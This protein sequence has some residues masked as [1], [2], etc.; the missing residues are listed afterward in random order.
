M[1]DNF[2][3]VEYPGMGIDDLGA[4]IR[5]MLYASAMSCCMSGLLIVGG[6]NLATYMYHRNV[7]SRKDELEAQKRGE[8]TDTARQNALVKKVRNQKEHDI[9]SM[10]GEIVSVAVIQLE[11]NALVLEFATGVPM[12]EHYD[13]FAHD[14]LLKDVGEAAATAKRQGDAGRGVSAL[15]DV[16][17]AMKKS[18]GKGGLMRSDGKM[19]GAIAQ[20]NLVKEAAEIKA[21]EEQAEAVEE[22]EEEDVE[23]GTQSGGKKAAMAK[24]AVL[25]PL[26]ATKQVTMAPVK[27][28]VGSGKMA[29]KAMGGKTKG[30][31]IDD[32]LQVDGDDSFV[33]DDPEL[34]E[35]AKKQQQ[36]EQ[37][38][39]AA[40]SGLGGMRGGGGLGAMA[41][42][43]VQETGKDLASLARQLNENTSNQQQSFQDNRAG[44]SIELEVRIKGAKDLME[45]AKQM[46]I[47]SWHDVSIF[48]KREMMYKAMQN[49]NEQ[50]NF[51]MGGPNM[52]TL[53]SNKL[54]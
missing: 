29:K 3:D 11:E 46:N 9:K 39:A 52:S 47:S 10:Q 34:D 43:G 21:A 8:G 38:L 36:K 49:Q 42:T 44:E 50:A 32:N 53:F 26:K 18:G 4:V 54:R 40:G 30:V 19:G 35:Q 2:A 12:E 16:A 15:P 48:Q 1:K 28:A 31:G 27:L 5:P 37:L 13:L 25:A 24:K 17:G 22:E 7:M 51:S 14:N 20:V 45:R 6:S 23:L 33:D 41:S